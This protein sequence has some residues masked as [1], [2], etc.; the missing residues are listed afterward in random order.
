L[1]PRHLCTTVRKFQNQGTEISKDDRSKDKRNLVLE[2]EED[3]IIAS[4]KRII[5][6]ISWDRSMRYMES[7]GEYRKD[8]SYP[9]SNQRL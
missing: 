9:G 6:Q 4:D 2:E 3:C 8:Y 1:K 5:P 7:E